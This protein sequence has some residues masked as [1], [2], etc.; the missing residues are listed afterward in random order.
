[1]RD[2]FRNVDRFFWNP[3]L[4]MSG[5]IPKSWWARELVMFKR[6]KEREALNH[7]YL[8]YPWG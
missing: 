7:P 6:R 5:N 8:S 3:W 4:F 2:F 1:M